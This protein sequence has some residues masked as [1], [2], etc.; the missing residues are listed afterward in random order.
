M[1]GRPTDNVG[2]FVLRVN[3]VAKSNSH[4]EETTVRIAVATSSGAN[5][6]EMIRKMASNRVGPSFVALLP[7][8]EKRATC[9]NPSSAGA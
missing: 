5:S 6:A 7:S 3:V 1:Y 4:Y 9:P 8:H 2:M